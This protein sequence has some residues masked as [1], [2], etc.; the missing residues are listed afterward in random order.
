MIV[1]VGTDEDALDACLAALDTAT[2]A[3][4]RV[5]LADDAQAG[6]RGNAIIERWLAQ[7]PLQAAHTRRASPIGEAAH[8]DE[9]LRACGSADVAILASDARPA[10]GWLERLQDCLASD[11]AIATATPWSNAGEAASWPRIG[12]IVDVDASPGRLARACAQLGKAHPSLPSAVTHA[13]LVRGAARLR[14]GG[15]DPASYRSWYAALID[16]SL[17]MSG[18]GWRNA[19]CETAFVGRGVEGLPAD[20]DMDALSVRWPAWHA[21]L[22][23]FLMD[24]PLRALRE[25]MGDALARLDSVPPQPDLFADAP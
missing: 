22:A 7:T 18:L 5:W 16:L 13:V 24:D 12:E 4:T 19:L 20:G 3:G 6:P 1:P 8:L 15:L 21:Q 25:R 11:P 14:A 9:A 2:P 23:H 10:P 17:R